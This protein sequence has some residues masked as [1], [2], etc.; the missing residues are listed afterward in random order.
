[1]PMSAD[2][3]PPPV[4][5]R[6]EYLAALERRA[7]VRG[8]RP[9]GQH[10]SALKQAKASSVLDNMVIVEYEAFPE[11]ARQWHEDVTAMIAAGQAKQRDLDWLERYDPYVAGLPVLRV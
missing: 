1:M 11:T 10:D 2:Q 7:T 8:E 4:P 6:A 9:P 5:K 3:L